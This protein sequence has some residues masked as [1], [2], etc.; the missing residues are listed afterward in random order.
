MKISTRTRYGI[1]AMLEIALH[2]GDVPVEM[3]VISKNQGISRKYLHTLLLALKNNGLLTSV[4]GTAGGYLLA[5]D[6]AEITV[7]EIFTI[8]EGSMNLVD[9][10]TDTGSCGRS[11]GC[12][13]R[14]IW[15][16]LSCLIRDE[17]DMLTLADLVSEHRMLGQAVAADN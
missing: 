15:D 4:R 6:P 12:V 11:A 13:T 5:R 17:L 9:C 16:R 10:V 2:P 3:S 8:L 1:R 14:N 7:Y